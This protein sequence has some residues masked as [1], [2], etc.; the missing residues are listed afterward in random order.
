MGLKQ[1]VID[2]MAVRQLRTAVRELDVPVENYRQKRSLAA[3]LGG[4]R[5]AT[6]EA[7][8]EFLSE[9]EVKRL[10]ARRGVDAK[11]RRRVLVARLLGS[12][13]AKSQTQDARGA[14]S[15]G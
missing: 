9:K 2:M 15:S 12:K 14:P 11:G 3:G 8:L 6:A 5:R 7:L 1:A 10:C 4:S 13:V